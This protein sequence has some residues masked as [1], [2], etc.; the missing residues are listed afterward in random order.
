MNATL[1]FPLKTRT[2]TRSPTEMWHILSGIS[3]IVPTTVELTH[4]LTDDTNDWL[5]IVVLDYE[6]RD[7]E[8][9]QLALAAGLDYVA[10]DDSMGLRVVGPRAAEWRPFPE[11]TFVRLTTA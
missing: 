8:L 2:G 11:L 10:V 7:H 6:L 5:L 3:M 1:N 4:N 9:Y